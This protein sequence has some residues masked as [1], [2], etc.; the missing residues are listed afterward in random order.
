VAVSPILLDWSEVLLVALVVIVALLVVV[1]S[2]LGTPVSVTFLTAAA[3][4]LTSI[5][6]VVALVVGGRRARLQLGIANLWRLI[7]S[8]D[9]PEMRRRRARMA[10]KLLENPDERTEVS[11]EGIDILN[12]FELLGFLLRSKTLSLEAAW[13][14]FPWALSWWY[15][16]ERGIQRLREGDSTVYQDYADLVESFIEYEMRSRGIG[17]VE[18]VP[19]EQARI[20]FL[21]SEVKLLRRIRI[22]DRWPL[23]AWRTR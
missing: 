5:L 11:D 6:A 14:N 7:E 21:N 19:T 1:L 3:A 2:A 16:Y 12:T 17:R 22:L 10:R 4:F 20:A 8:W 23:G 15:V 18:V 13:I 9:H